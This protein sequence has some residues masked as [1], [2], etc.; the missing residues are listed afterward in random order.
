M[1]TIQVRC[2]A[3]S[4]PSPADATVA[5]PDAAPGVYANPPLHCAGCGGQVHTV[6]GEP[7]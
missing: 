5:L 7:R 3:T 2:F 6:T 4:C 1:K